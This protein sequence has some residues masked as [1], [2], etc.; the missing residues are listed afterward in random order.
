M[1]VVTEEHY[2]PERRYTITKYIASDGKEFHAK[3]DCSRHEEQLEIM[4]HPVFKNCIIDI[5][6][7]DDEYRGILYYLSSEDDYKF[8]IKCLGLKFNDGINSNFYDYGKGWYLYWC[9]DWG[10]CSAHHHIY[11]YNA[12]VEEIETDLKEWKDAIQNKMNEV[13]VI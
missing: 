12:Y 10:D 11:N 2:V 7:F 1:K 13:N 6:T 8:L 4:S 3:A 5:H 9:E